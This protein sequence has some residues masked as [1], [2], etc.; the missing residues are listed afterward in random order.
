LSRRVVALSGRPTRV[1]NVHH[2]D[3]ERGS[4]VEARA[5]RRFPEYFHTLCGELDIQ[6]R[7]KAA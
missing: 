5:D 7:K 4:P 6:T 1:K 3:I 2:I